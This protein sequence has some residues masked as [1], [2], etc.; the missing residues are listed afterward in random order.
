[1]LAG[2]DNFECLFRAL[3]NID[4]TTLKVKF[5]GMSHREEKQFA[6]LYNERIGCGT[7]SQTVFL[8]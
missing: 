8:K 2:Q 1:M 3:S 6:V 5:P 7:Q 4:T